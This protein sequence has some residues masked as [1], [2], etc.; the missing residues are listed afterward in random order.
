MSRSIAS[1]REQSAEEQQQKA[2]LRV[3]ENEGG[4]LGAHRSMQR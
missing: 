1:L 2:A 3:W 4:S